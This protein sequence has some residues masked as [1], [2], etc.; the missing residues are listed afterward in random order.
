MGYQGVGKALASNLGTEVGII[1]MDS[2]PKI[3]LLAL[4]TDSSSLQTNHK[5]HDVVVD[6]LNLGESNRACLTSH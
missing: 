2:S 5:S 3:N 1:H 4:D 6:K